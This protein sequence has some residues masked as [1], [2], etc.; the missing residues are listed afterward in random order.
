MSNPINPRLAARCAAALTLLILLAPPWARAVR[1]WLFEN[2]P[3][4]ALTILALLAAVSGAPLLLLVA[5]GLRGMSPARWTVLGCGLAGLVLLGL[6][7]ATDDP[8]VGAVERLHLLE[9]AT[10]AA[11]LLRALANW[12]PDWTRAVWTMLLALLVAIGDESFQWLL[13]LRTAELRDVLLDVGAAAM[14]LFM[15]LALERAPLAGSSARSRAKLLAGAAGVVLPLSG[16][17]QL[18]HCGGW[19]ADPACGRFRSF[20]SGP[21]L[22]ERDRKL[23]GDP[24]RA[25]RPPPLLGIEDY[26]VTEAGWHLQHRNL[27]L[28]RGDLVTVL[29]EQRI[30]ERF[31]G[32][33]LRAHNAL[34]NPG[35]R[36]RAAVLAGPPA[37][38]VSPVLAR[39]IWVDVTPMRLW[40]WAGLAALL[41]I[42]LARR[43][44]A[45]V[46]AGA[47]ALF[48]RP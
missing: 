4:Q 12:A 45:G 14:G 46:A 18:A 41:F 38:Y 21:E 7:F 31:Y 28:E 24:N 8:R 29:G 26:A 25:L 27:A 13:P 32:A 10:L 30:L 1:D 33:F 3:Q 34:L 23:S 9:Y 44:R 48:H 5:R 37:G 11:L 6:G 15:G 43:A 17:I 16:F 19:V 47:P 20:F 42:A 22:L 2:A 36:R 39:R 40:S 35:L